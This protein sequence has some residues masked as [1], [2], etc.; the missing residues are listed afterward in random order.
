VSVFVA[1]NI[2]ADS[3]TGL[4]AGAGDI[5]VASAAGVPSGVVGKPA[6]SGAKPAAGGELV[7]ALFSSG[8][9]WALAETSRLAAAAARRFKKILF[10]GFPFRVAA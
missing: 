1:G 7:A 6:A 3:T 10:I 5:A 8:T 4:S 2:T 9:G